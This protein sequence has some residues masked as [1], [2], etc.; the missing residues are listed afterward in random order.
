MKAAVLTGIRRL[1][2]REVAQ[3]VLADPE[4]AMVRIAAVGICGSDVHYY[5]T[6]RIGSQAVKYPETIGHECAGTITAVGSTVAGLNNGQRVSI[7]PLISC[8]WC[9]QCRAGRPHTCRNQRFLGCPGQAPGALAEYISIPAR[10]CYPVPDSMSLEEAAFV[11]PLSI[12]VHAQRISGMGRDAKIAILGCGPI[13]LSV[14]LA[15][16]EA[17]AGAIFATDLLDAR[18]RMAS[19]CGAGW[20]GNAGTADVLAGIND[21]EPLGLDYVFECAGEQQALHHAVELLKPGGTLVIVGIP[22]LDRVSFDPHLL[23]R[24]ELRIVN[25]RRQNQCMAAAIELI[26]SGAVKVGELLTHDFPLARAREALELVTNRSEGVI[27]A[28]VHVC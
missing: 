1:E 4:C 12:G 14:L 27:K 26:S 10:C 28:I 21:A 24:K 13:G 16:R 25:V 22:E 9:D 2:I 5:T 8:A 15:C 17:G 18:L 23:R 3:P 7:D 20:T 11:E 19:R 6:G